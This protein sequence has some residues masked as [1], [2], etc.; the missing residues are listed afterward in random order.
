VP[1]SRYALRLDGASERELHDD[2]GRA[3][4]PLAL[5]ILAAGTPPPPEPKKPA[6]KK[7]RR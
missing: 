4:S 2:A 1:G 5:P 7:G 3:F 6:P